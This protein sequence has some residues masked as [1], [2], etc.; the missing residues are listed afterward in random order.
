MESVLD[1]I[2]LEQFITDLEEG[3][4]QWVYWHQLQSVAEALNMAEAYAEAEKGARQ[5]KCLSLDICVSFLLSSPSFYPF[6][7]REERM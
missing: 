4:Q 6:Q 2:V 3:T 7:K 1:V 5:K